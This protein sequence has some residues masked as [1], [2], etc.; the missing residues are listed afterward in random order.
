MSDALASESLEPKDGRAP[1]PSKQ[2]TTARPAL[3]HPP[4]ASST[5][6]VG[7]DDSKS[8]ANTDPSSQP[9]QQLLGLWGIS[10]PEQTGNM[11]TNESISA[12]I[13]ERAELLANQA[14]TLDSTVRSLFSTT[15]GESSGSLQL[16][17]DALFEDSHY[18]RFRLADRG[19]SRS[20][21]M[22][23]SDIDGV[24]EGMASLALHVAD[25]KRDRFI[26]QWNK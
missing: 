17:R 1:S 22:L 25:G 2:Q 16:I 24:K 15:L 23:E 3:Q 20:L 4:S 14:T 6:S 5:R 13:A 8:A 10:M 18:G 7:A 19:L 26:E 21:D 12:A 9:I 11:N